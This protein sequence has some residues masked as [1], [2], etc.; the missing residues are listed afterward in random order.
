MG[1]GATN[2]AARE[3]WLR[4]LR[5]YP[6]R[7]PLARLRGEISKTLLELG[8]CPGGPTSSALWYRA[9]PGQSQKWQEW[10][11]VYDWTEGE[12]RGLV[13]PSVE[14]RNHVV[15][16]ENLLTGE[17]MYALF[18]HVARTVEGLGQGW[19]SY[20]PPDG[21]APQMV[22][23]V[24]AVI[25][26][27]GVRRRHQYSENF[28]DGTETRL[29]RAA[30]RYVANRGIVPAEVERQLLDTGAGIPSSEGVV[31]AP[32]RLTMAAPPN[33]DGNATGFR[34]P[35][36]SGFYLHPVGICPE[37]PK[38]TALEPAELTADYDYYAELTKHAELASFRLHAQ[39]LS[40]QTD[41]DD[42]PRRQRWFQDIFVA[43][44]LPLVHGIDLLSVTTTM[45]AGVDIGAL[46]AVMMANMPPRRFNYQ[47]RV[48]RA[49]R[50]AEGVSLAVTFCRGRS[51]D[52]F[53][54]QRPESMTA[55]PPSS[56]YVD[57]RSEPIFRRVL[58]KEVLRHAFATKLPEIG[59]GGGDNVHGPFGSAV[60]WAVVAPEVQDWLADPYYQDEIEGVIATLA[61]GTRWAGSDGAAFR[62]RMLAYLRTELVS[63]ITAIVDDPSF[64]QDA[65]SERLANAG[66]LPMFGFPT[67]GRLLHSRWPRQAY[68]WP[69]EG[70]TVDRDLDVAISQFA[71]GS[72]TVKDKQV[73]TAVG[74]VELRPLGNT[75]ATG[76]GFF[77]PLPYPNPRPTGLCGR[78]QALVPLDGPV[79]AGNRLQICP[80]CRDPES[81]LRVIDAREPKGF[82]TDLEPQDFDGQFE[83]QPVSTRPSMAFKTEGLP[84]VERINNVAV[85]TLTDEIMSINDGGGQDGFPFQA[86]NL[87]GAPKSGAYAVDPVAINPTVHSRIST[88]GP[89]HQVS[90]LSRRMTDILL[91]D[92]STWP[93]GV[94]AD[95]MTVEGR[96]AWYSFAFWLR[97]AAGAYLDVDPLELQ[98]GFRSIARGERVVGQAFLCDQLE[99]GAGY[100]RELARPEEFRRLLEQASVATEGSIGR[101]WTEQTA[102]QDVATPHGAE[103]DTSCNRCLRDFHNLPYHGLL[104][105]R[106]ALDVA[107]VATSTSALVDLGSDWDHRPNPW[108][109]LAD[110]PGS[111]VAM[112]LGRLGYGDP[113]PFGRLR[114][115]VHRSPRRKKLLI[116]RHPLWQDNHPEWVSA[117]H[118]AITRYPGY[119]V[120]PAN[121]FRVMRRPADSL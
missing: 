95:P 27:L 93:T 90:L 105:W 85:S 55:D 13:N 64:T 48:G 76:N 53:Y 42:R 41:S 69:S 68:P 66:L 91:A 81:S 6:S 115:Y 56:P 34:C 60:G 2:G 12:P 72:Q 46:N 9:A 121:P 5:A 57:M 35:E 102:T 106:L 83:W 70:G 1:M 97:L 14:Q 112:T 50:R 71:P 114:G 52:D 25:R 73:H 101:A 116:E 111:R 103:C 79:D 32:D 10:Y 96:A 24:D 51:H 28:Y 94:F 45:E 67:R 92:V 4:L 18:R 33:G 108:V 38:P 118:E 7:I 74:V 47:Q 17:L 88:F 58:V 43:D 36:C 99:N 98:G 54:F 59:I 26:Q 61:V 15:R 117:Q 62:A 89:V 20:Q 107:R 49:G 63:V 31:L 19:V 23:V 65:L 16:M 75:V 11:A 37:C 29:H 77:P 87:D 84:A 30:A 119:T 39:E 21:V 44:E 109:T 100:C 110:G 22:E 82:F 104:D 3:E 80:V 40:G 86:V 78:C 113:E 8:M 120:T